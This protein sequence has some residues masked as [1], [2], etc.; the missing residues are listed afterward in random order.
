MLRSIN[1]GKSRRFHPLSKV[2]LFR[3]MRS[4]SE[5]G[6]TISINKLRAIFFSMS[7]ADSLKSMDV[8]RA[9]KWRKYLEIKRDFY[10]AYVSHN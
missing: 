2:N 7:T 3:E 8:T 9:G 10:L 6:F 1:T 5:A 4:V